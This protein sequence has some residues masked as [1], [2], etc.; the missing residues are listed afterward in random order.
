MTT[1]V[2]QVRD[3]ALVLQL[4]AAEVGGTGVLTPHSVPEIGG[5]PVAP[6]NPMPTALVGFPITNTAGGACSAT[7]GQATTS[8]IVPFS[9]TRRVLHLFNRSTGAE[10]MDIGPTAGVTSGT[11]IPIACGGSFTFAGAGASG[12]FFAVSPVAS[13]PYSYA[14]G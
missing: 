13:T 8:P 2:L 9:A 11:G 4:L 5:A 7:A 3:A 10:V 1:T 14:E 6:S 12:P